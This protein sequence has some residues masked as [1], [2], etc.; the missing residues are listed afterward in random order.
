[1]TN[2]EALDDSRLHAGLSVVLALGFLAFAINSIARI[3]AEDAYSAFWSGVF[4][5]LF[6]AAAIY[7]SVRSNTLA[8]QVKEALLSETDSPAANPR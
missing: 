1:M 8:R 3:K 2:I 5:V 6:A 4:M 7:S